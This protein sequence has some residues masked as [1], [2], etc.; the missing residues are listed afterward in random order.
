MVNDEQPSQPYRMGD[1]VFHLTLIS[2]A[3]D[4]GVSKTKY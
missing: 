2:I 4:D 1:N 3:V